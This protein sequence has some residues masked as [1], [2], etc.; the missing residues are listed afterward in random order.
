[1]DYSGAGYEDKA[2][3]DLPVKMLSDKRAESRRASEDIIE[4]KDI[5][6]EDMAMSD[7]GENRVAINTDAFKDVGELIG[8]PGM[9][10]V[11]TLEEQLREADL[12]GE[13]T[14]ESIRLVEELRTKRVNAEALRLKKLEEDRKR[15]TKESVEVKYERSKFFKNISRD[16]SV[17]MLCSHID[18]P[19]FG[20]PYPLF[21]GSSAAGRGCVLSFEFTYDRE[22]LFRIDGRNNKLLT[23]YNL[24]NNMSRVVSHITVEN[25]DGTLLVGG[26]EATDV[27]AAD[28]DKF[29][30]SIVKIGV[31]FADE[32]E[33]F[34][35]YPSIFLEWACGFEPLKMK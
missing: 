28:E 14:P 10:Q 30:K 6:I 3:E 22:A 8:K 23:F 18:G 9:K 13:I 19:N 12:P 27:M 24:K 25:R 35:Y 26:N 32:V 20:V 29:R 7:Y 31:P 15:L 16:A 33:L 34:D 4:D 5:S 11:F 2:A 21:D 1:M 17:V